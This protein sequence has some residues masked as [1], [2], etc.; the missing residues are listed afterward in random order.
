MPT[1]FQVAYGKCGRELGRIPLV[2]CTAGSAQE[3]ADH[4]LADRKPGEPSYWVTLRGWSHSL[5]G[6]ASGKIGPAFEKH[7]VAA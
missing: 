1:Q 6:L 7:E 5:R 4:L 2:F 3:V